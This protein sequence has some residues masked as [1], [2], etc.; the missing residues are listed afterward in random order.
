MATQTADI[1]GLV[2]AIVEPLV[3][4]KDDVDVR[5]SIDEYG[6]IY[7]EVSVNDE[8]TGKVYLNEVNPIPGSLSFY[9]WEP[10]GVPYPVLLDRLI[11][12]ALR[13]K[14]RSKNRISSFTSN[15]L[16]QGGFKGKK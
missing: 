6:N 10:K 12:I 7:C 1:A 15:I 16:A 8:D 2:R 13:S 4:H 5:Q 9:L 3:D 14:Q 11:Q